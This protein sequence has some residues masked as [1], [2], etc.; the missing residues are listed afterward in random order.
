MNHLKLIFIFVFILIGCIDDELDDFK[1]FY[2]N[3]KNVFIRLNQMVFQLSKDSIYSISYN[4]SILSYNDY[5]EVY[6]FGG[7]KNEKK[8]SILRKL[9]IL[10]DD[11]KIKRTNYLGGNRAIYYFSNNNI[12]LKFNLFEDTTKCIRRGKRYVVLPDSFYIEET[13]ALS[14]LE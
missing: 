2:L 9:K 8:D 10:L 6:D 5:N 3:N 11:L 12:I 1:I 13:S 14:A 4:N 7:D